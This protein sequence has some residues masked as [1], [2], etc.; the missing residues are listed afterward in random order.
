MSVPSGMAWINGE[1]LPTSEA[2]ISV[3]D[4]GFIGGAAV[5]DTLACWKGSIFKLQQHLERFQRSAHAAAISAAV[6]DP[7]Q[8]NVRTNAFASDWT[9]G[10]C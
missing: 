3:F 7:I 10:R 2:T 6:C 5:F 8:R 1:F 4:N 9:W